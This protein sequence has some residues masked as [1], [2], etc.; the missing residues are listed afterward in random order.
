MF[1]LRAGASPDTWCIVTI[2]RDSTAPMN[3]IAPGAGAVWNVLD[4]YG[5]SLGD[6]G[7]P[8]GQIVLPSSGANAWYVR[9]AGGTILR[10]AIVAQVRALAAPHVA[11][12][13]EL[14]AIAPEAVAAIE[15]LAH[16]ELP[17][18]A[19]LHFFAL[20]RSLPALEEGWRR[21][22]VETRHAIP[23]IRDFALMAEKLAVLEQELEEPLLEPL[24]K[25]MDTCTQWLQRY[26]E[27]ADPGPLSAHRLEFLRGEVARFTDEARA[28]E[29]AG[30][31]IEAKAIA[32]LAEWRARSLEPAATL[33]WPEPDLAPVA[34]ETPAAPAADD[35]AP[36]EAEEDPE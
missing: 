33:F 36:L 27:P 1:R 32:A 3:A 23:M 34:D 14:A 2:V 13:G 22:I 35:E 4:A 5:N 10:D 24:D 19:R 7:R 15:A 26:S 30:R 28:L 8:D 20:L 11:N 16:Y 9:G 12:S 31:Q 17:A 21:G 6:A 25:T 29:T 18:P